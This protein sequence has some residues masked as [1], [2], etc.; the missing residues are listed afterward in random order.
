[1]VQRVD[2]FDVRPVGEEG[3]PV[4][5][6]GVVGCFWRELV[7]EGEVEHCLCGVDP[8]VAVAAP[9][10]VLGESVFGVGE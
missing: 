2:G 10:L 8:A 1:M 5:L 3:L 9:V 7:V 4:G 6:A